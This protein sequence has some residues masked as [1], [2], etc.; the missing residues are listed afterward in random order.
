MHHLTFKKQGRQHMAST[1]EG[2]QLSFDDYA[3]DGGFFFNKAGVTTL[4]KQSLIIEE[5]EEE[6]DDDDTDSK[7]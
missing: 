7:D 3:E 5:E 1:S 2:K 6:D 4:R